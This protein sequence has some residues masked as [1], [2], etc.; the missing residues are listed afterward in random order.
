M[1]LG[2]LLAR[3]GVDVIVL[4]KHADFFR[5][6]RGD[7]IHP[8]TLQV[9]DELGMLDD[10]LK[11]PHQEVRQLTMTFGQDTVPIM[12]FTGLPTRCKFIAFAPQ[13]DF[14]NFL[15]AKAKSYPTF[16]LR[17]SSEVT[18]LLWEGEKVTGVKVRT[19]TGMLE[20]RADLVV[21]SD[22]R[23]SVVR[24]RAGLQI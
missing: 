7:T 23:S 17:M 22:G 18:D 16:Q 2:L 24:E 10:F 14:L 5:D 1:M 15:A 8:S 9:L 12:D 3:T 19:P 21:G 4:E 20:V 6:F 11:L 13:W